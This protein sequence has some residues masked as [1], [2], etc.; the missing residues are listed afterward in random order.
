MTNGADEGASVIVDPGYSTAT[1]ARARVASG[2][3]VR[4]PFPPRIVLAGQGGFTRSLVVPLNDPLAPRRAPQRL[5]ECHGRY[6]SS[7]PVYSAVDAPLKA[8]INAAPRRIPIPGGR[9]ESRQQRAT[10]QTP[11]NTHGLTRSTGTVRR[12]YPKLWVLPLESRARLT[13]D[14]AH[15]YGQKQSINFHVGSRLAGQ[16]M[17]H[18]SSS[19]ARRPVAITQPRVAVLRQLR[20]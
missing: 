18:A 12:R 13:G 3:I 15:D 6:R 10:G 2:S 14:R 9:G 16:Y 4:D 11:Q 17:S 19:V 20:A 7:R 1:S 5:R 8:A